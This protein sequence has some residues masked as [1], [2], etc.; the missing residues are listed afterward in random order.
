MPTTSPRSAATFSPISSVDVELDGLMSWVAPTLVII[1]VA[2]IISAHLLLIA[3][4]YKV[5]AVTNR[6][7]NLYKIAKTASSL[8]LLVEL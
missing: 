4:K 3:I 1:N 6:Y 8:K 5:S 7:K 2:T